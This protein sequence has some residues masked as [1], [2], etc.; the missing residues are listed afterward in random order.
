MDNR[1]QII[2][3][4]TDFN[5]SYICMLNTV[6]KCSKCKKNNTIIKNSNSIKSQ[7]C[8]FCGNPN[9]IEYL[10]KPTLESRVFTPLKI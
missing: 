9:Y 7:N 4:K 8:L 3:Q 6:F 5:Q 10:K 2:Y 1:K